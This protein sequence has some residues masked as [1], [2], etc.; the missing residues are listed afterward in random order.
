MLNSLL[1]TFVKLKRPVHSSVQLH[2]ILCTKIVFV[3]IQYVCVLNEIN[4][5]KSQFM[6]HSLVKESNQ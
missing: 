5:L 2:C 3:K 6:F 1:I 4:N